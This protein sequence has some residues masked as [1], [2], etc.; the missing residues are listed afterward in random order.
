MKAKYQKGGRKNEYRKV[1]RVEYRSARVYWLN[2][3]TWARI[4]GRKNSEMLST[5]GNQK[6]FSATES[7][8][9]SPET[10]EKLQ[11]IQALIEYW[12]RRGGGY[13]MRPDSRYTEKFLKGLT[14]L[15]GCPIKGSAVCKRKQPFNIL[16]HPRIWNQMKNSSKR[17][18]CSTSSLP[19]TTFENL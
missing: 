19:P 8:D 16:E 10:S 4:Y 15:T 5:R 2:C 17:S 6:L 11:S 1:K 7:A 9:L 13:N 18:G 3:L 14:T 12:I